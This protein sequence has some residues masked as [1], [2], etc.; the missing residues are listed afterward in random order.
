MKGTR[1]IALANCVLQL[2]AC[3]QGPDYVRPTSEVP[4]GYR[5]ANHPAVTPQLTAETAW[6]V[7][8]GDPRLNALVQEALANNRDLRIATARVDEFEAILAGTRAQGLPQVGYG[9]SANHSRAS[10]QIIPSFVDPHSTTFSGL[11][12]AS[13]E[14]DLWGR[15]RRETEAA[16][17][18]LLATEEARRGVTLTLISSVIVGYVT[19]LDLD[20]QLRVSEATVAGRR[21]NVQ[22]FEERL[23]SG[24]ISEFEMSQVRGEYEIAVAA[25]PP[26]R[27]AI[28]VQENALS[29]LLGH[30]P[31]TD[32]SGIKPAIASSCRRSGGLAIG[33]SDPSSRYPASGTAA[34][35][36]KRAD[37]RCARP[38]LPPHHADWPVRICE[39]LTRW[40]V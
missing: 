14:I 27:Q 12:S 20:E 33:A 30:N 40:P 19:L 38:V 16:R 35:R 8:F 39:R 6:W 26:I 25:I 17:A 34:H 36:L 23:R 21:H 11:L 1:S 24:W 32:C 7:A 10:E 4:S 15:I 28:A 18:N 13:W 29:V 2:G 37:R 22:L 3:V 9:L 31:A 5:F